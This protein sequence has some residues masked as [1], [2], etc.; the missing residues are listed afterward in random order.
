M[1]R[2]DGVKIT[3]VMTRGNNLI[4]KLDIN[5][6]MLVIIIENYFHQA[7]PNTLVAGDLAR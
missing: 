5:C 6:Y 3:Q 2:L 7:A 4:Y 1:L